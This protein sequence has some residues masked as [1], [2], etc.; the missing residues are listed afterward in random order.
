M[1]EITETKEITEH[2]STSSIGLA[3]AL[4]ALGAKHEDTDKN[5]PRHMIFYFSQPSTMPVPD[6]FQTEFTLKD[7]ELAWSN[8]S[9]IGNLIDFVDA[10]GRMKSIVHSY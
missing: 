8:K 4:L 1:I 10:F 5:N 3:S 6:G 7:I 9:L 2:F